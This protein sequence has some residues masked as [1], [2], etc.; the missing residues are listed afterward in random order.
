MCCPKLSQRTCQCWS[1]ISP[2]HIHNRRN[3]S[4]FSTGTLS[5]FFSCGEFI[6]SW[7]EH[8]CDY[9]K[10]TTP[11]VWV[12]MSLSTLC[13]LFSLISQ[14]AGIGKGFKL[15]IE[16][17]LKGFLKIYLLQA[18]ALKILQSNY[19]NSSWPCKFLLF[20]PSCENVHI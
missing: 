19:T 2:N 17:G 3:L 13:M 7:S 4:S 1:G 14:Q 20:I 11:G 5:T 15:N 12:W 9:L 18:H 16:K 8:L 6:L 10:T